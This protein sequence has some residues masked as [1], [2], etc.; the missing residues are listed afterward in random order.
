MGIPGVRI[1]RRWY[2][3]LR[4][5]GAVANEE[6]SR[7]A[8]QAKHVRCAN[9]PDDDLLRFAPR[10]LLSPSPGPHGEPDGGLEVSNSLS[11]ERSPGAAALAPPRPSGA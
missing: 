4:K 9:A 3:Q 8:D 6:T 2:K 1:G 7:E 5:S 10:W 11:E